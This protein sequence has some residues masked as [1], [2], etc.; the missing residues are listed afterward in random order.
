[1]Y[2]LVKY[3][4]DS[5]LHVVPTKSLQSIEEGQL[6]WAPYKKMGY[7]EA[8]P[9]EYGNIRAELEKKKRKMKDD[10][11]TS[12]KEQDFH[13]EAEKDICMGGRNSDGKDIS[14]EN[15]CQKSDTISNAESLQSC[16]EDDSIKDPDYVEESDTSSEST[17]IFFILH[18][19]E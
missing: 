11:I 12:N 19:H 14:T 1:M 9:L 6:V 15:I 18:V 4:D 7:Y 16:S 13:C 2:C 3:V 10:T 17:L 5:I 8:V